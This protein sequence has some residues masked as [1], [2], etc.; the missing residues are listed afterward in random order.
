M[1]ASSS[2]ELLNKLKKYYEKL[3]EQ[4]LSSEDVDNMVELSK[5]LYERCVILR[6]K[7][8]EQKVFGEKEIQIDAAHRE[9]I[10]QAAVASITPEPTIDF[11]IF[12]NRQEEPIEEEQPIEIV[13]SMTEEHID[14][15]IA[16]EPELKQEIQE[17]TF[18]QEVVEESPDVL[19]SSKPDSDWS[20]LMMEY[21][22][23]ESHSFTKSLDQIS[24]SFGLNERLMYCNE[25]FDGDTD[26]FGTLVKTLDDAGSWENCLAKLIDTAEQ[27]NWDKESDTI[28][29][30][31]LHVKR[32]YA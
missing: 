3:E 29:D 5:S 13:Q 6:Y 16:S 14:E 2:K 9:P 8:I 24:S 22:Q 18:I 31:V 28:S 23:R 12:E 10:S 30:F 11:G 32:K 25:L 21:A 20:K 17:E 7:A 27:K 26:S 4:K 15:I 19:K 1:Q